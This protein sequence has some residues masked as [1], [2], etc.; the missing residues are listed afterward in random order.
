MKENQFKLKAG[1]TLMS[2]DG[3]L[4]CFL[5]LAISSLCF[6][7]SSDGI[8][9]ISFLS[10]P[11]VMPVERAEWDAAHSTYSLLC[12]ASFPTSIPLGASKL[13]RSEKP[14]WCL[15]PGKFLLLCFTRN[16]NI[17]QMKCFRTASTKQ[18][19]FPN[20]QCKQKTFQ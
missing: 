4:F 7:F 2:K 19:D 18:T 6:K 3:E 9:F 12:E 1:K 14:H 11:T 15:V 20:T 10:Q 5:F 13:G 8:H 16:P 17:T